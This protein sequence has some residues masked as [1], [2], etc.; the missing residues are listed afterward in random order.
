MAKIVGE[1]QATHAKGV[2]R[3]HRVSPRASGATS[4]ERPPGAGFQLHSAPNNGAERMSIQPRGLGADLDRLC[5]AAAVGAGA[6]ARGHAC[7]TAVA[8]SSA[9]GR[10]A[11]PAAPPWCTVIAPAPGRRNASES[12]PCR[13]D[14]VHI[15]SAL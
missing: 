2:R 10:A 8:G 13:Y 3:S 4:P 9:S 5:L 12:A 6:A 11:S 7:P 1:G 14:D 15:Q